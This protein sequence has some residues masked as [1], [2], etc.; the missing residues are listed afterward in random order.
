[1][2]QNSFI[3]NR[4]YPQFDQDEDDEGILSKTGSF[5]SSLFNKVVNTINPFKSK[6]YVQNPYDLN[7]LNDPCKHL[8]KL[9]Q[10]NNLNVS[11]DNQKYYNKKVSGINFTGKGQIYLGNNEYD[12]SNEINNDKIFDID[13]EYFTVEE[14]CN[15]SP[16]LRNEIYKDIKRPN[17]IPNEEI[18]QKAKKYVYDNLVK[19]YKIMKPKTNDKKDQIF[20]E[21]I[22]LLAIQL[23]NK[24]N[25]EKQYDSL[26]N[27]KRIDNFRIEI[28]VPEIIKNYYTNKAKTLYH[29]DITENAQEIDIKL[30]KELFNQFSQGLV[31]SEKNK[32][33]DSNIN[34]SK[35]NRIVCRTPR[36]KRNYLDSIFENKYNYDYLCPN[37]KVRCQIYKECLRY[38][39][40][41]LRNY[42]RVIEATN[43]MFK[44]VCNEN[45]K[46][47]QV[48]KEKEEKIE[49]YTKQI[50]LNK[51][52]ENENIQKIHNYEN[53]INS[54]K[55]KPQ[56][57]FGNLQ[58]VNNNII[59][60]NSN[61]L[62]PNVSSN[63]NINLSNN[64]FTLKKPLEI[65][66]NF[67]FSSNKNV[68]SGEKT[69]SFPN[70][71]QNNSSIFSHSNKNNNDPNLF[72]VLK[73]Q[74]VDQNDSQIKNE[75][76]EN[77]IKNVSKL[78]GFTQS[79]E[80]KEELEN[81]IENK[82]DK[83]EKK[84]EI[85]FFKN[86]NPNKNEKQLLNFG[87]VK[88]KKEEQKDNNK[89][90]DIKSKL[91]GNN[92]IIFGFLKEEKNENKNQKEENKDKAENELNNSLN[93][94]NKKNDFVENS[95]EK[96]KESENEKINSSNED[97]KEENNNTKNINIGIIEEKKEEIKGEIIEKKEEKKE[98]L[99]N[100]N[101]PFLSVVNIKTNEEFS[102][103]FLNNSKDKDKKDI[104]ERS[105]LDTVNNIVK[106]GDSSN[107]QSGS[108]NPFVNTE[109]NFIPERKNYTQ[110]NPFTTSQNSINDKNN[111]VFL[112][113]ADIKKD[114][115]F[116]KNDNTNSN[117]L[118]ANILNN[119]VKVSNFNEKQNLNNTNINNEINSN[120]NISN[121][122]F[123]S[124]NKS[125]S[126][127][128][129]SNNN[130]FI[131]FGAS[132]SLNTN[133]SKSEN[134]FISPINIETQNTFNNN[135]NNIK[136]SNNPFISS[137]TNAIVSTTSNNNSSNNNI[138]TSSNNP[139]LSINN[140][141]NGSS[142]I[143]NNNSNPFFKNN[144]PS[145]I[146]S[147]V[148]GNNN[149]NTSSSNTNVLFNFKLN[150][151]E[152][153]KVNPF[154][155]NKN[156]FDF[157]SSNNSNN[158]F[159]MGVNMRKNGNNNYTSIFDDN[160]SRKVNGF[161]N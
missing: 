136:S 83:S 5:I 93:D 31:F 124:I 158:S 145:L 157:S 87:F 17:Y 116:N 30:D 42:A 135:T 114:T 142:N 78:L 125:L 23:T 4:N 126:Q 28:N 77:E 71:F 137:L 38:K 109:N 152:S 101:N 140:N 69:A 95:L 34:N 52:K 22:L 39:E 12:D 27:D 76:K 119:S 18:F 86:N 35:E 113:F 20:G 55:N 118:F 63:N 154:L 106:F 45:E 26:V 19:K 68:I 67:T 131:S 156:G 47:R 112:N 40:N 59:N 57:N 153:N 138:S 148:F 85:N 8:N 123:L 103:K 61:I 32:S 73:S 44:F 25:I 74:K 7:S 6:K 144:D 88:E 3:I 48:I 143:S 133:L 159:A 66:T 161:Y 65:Q 79:E 14:L 16:H 98:S 13:E 90:D 99:N 49:E 134:P 41:E 117:N 72:L 107:R 29:E 37:D 33:N 132:T 146:N 54:L 89:K 121:N 60:Q 102:T 160:R 129:N 139:F 43:N 46:L 64:I 21:S 122:P 56:S 80:K 149:N 141:N 97:K 111:N 155:T 11:Y 115:T 92:K 128:N 130:P 94:T 110:E 24:Y 50:I 91:E 104:S 100:P 36:T 108:V 10:G 150:T 127:N 84:E 120:N 1:M 2:N 82:E 151:Q 15:A 81:I 53:E 70:K 147:P 58:E 62:Q 75:E 105:T 9:E 51:I 96:Q